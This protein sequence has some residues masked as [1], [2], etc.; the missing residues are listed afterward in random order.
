MIRSRGVLDFSVHSL[1]GLILAASHIHSLFCLPV[2]FAL[3]FSRI[4]P[5]PFP[6]AC[7]G[8]LI[9]RWI[10]NKWWS[11]RRMKFP[12]PGQNILVPG[13][14]FRSPRQFSF[15]VSRLFA[16]RSWPLVCLPPPP[17][18]AAALL[19]LIILN[20]RYLLRG[21][22]VCVCTVCACACTALYVRTSVFSVFSSAACWEGRYVERFRN[23]ADTVSRLASPPGIWPVLRSRVVGGGCRGRKRG[24]GNRRKRSRVL[25]DMN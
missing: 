6:P 11:V 14:H 25:W 20:L 8:I 22:C 18:C 1:R 12:P 21:L 17:L 3:T 15:E 5:P 24:E 13:T 2:F 19:A 23:R 10:T 4:R 9:A 7:H 16:C